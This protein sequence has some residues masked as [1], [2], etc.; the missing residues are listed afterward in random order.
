MTVRNVF[1]GTGA[2]LHIPALCDVEVASALRRLLLQGD[3]SEDRA[4]EAVADYLDLPL[5]R[6]G[7]EHL[8]ARV[9]SLRTNFSAHDATYIALAERLGATLV[10]GDQQLARAAGNHLVVPLVLV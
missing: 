8:V 6:H 2:P 1:R 9:L 7:H 3:L 10:T 5:A 4:K